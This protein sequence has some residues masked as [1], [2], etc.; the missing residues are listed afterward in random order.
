MSKLW[1][2]YLV[3]EDLIG[4]S[5]SVYQIRRS[6]PI[7]AKGD[8]P[9]LITGE[10]GTE[11][12]LLARLIIESSGR[13]KAPVLITDAAKLNKT[14]DQEVQTMLQQQDISLEEG[15]QGTLIVQNLEYLDREA[16]ARLMSFAQ[17]GYLQLQHLPDPVATDFR[18]ITTATGKLQEY[19]KDGMFNSELYLTLSAMTVKL[20]SVRER[21]QD[22]VAFFEFYLD[23][24]CRKMGRT[25]PPMPFEIF[26]QILKYS[27]PGN[28]KEIENAVRSVVVS[29]PEGQLLI[30]TLPFVDEA[31]K[32]QR[33]ELQ[34]LNRAVAQLEKEM[35]ERALRRFAGNQSRAAQ[36][37]HLSEPNLRFKMKKLGIRKEE[38][39]MGSE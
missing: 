14:F 26:H 16:Q 39:I 24:F 23:Y 2:E 36:V 11:K 34:N 13:K 32:F 30:E 1:E 10:P 27:W 28:V 33:V 29:S 17:G 6:I 15:L 37:L 35:I 25:V 9:V 5:P 19:A 21:K 18:I 20:P 31:E 38:F 8:Q 12:L 4:H 3:Q 22:I 7:L